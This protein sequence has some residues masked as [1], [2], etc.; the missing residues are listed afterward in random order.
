MMLNN[1]LLK[2]KLSWFKPRVIVLIESNQKQA[3]KFIFQIMP[4]SFLF[5]KEIL[6]IKNLKN[7]D[8]LQRGEY[9]ILNND[10]I[11]KPVLKKIK[12]LTFGFNQGAD[13]QISDLNQSKKTSFSFQR[14]ASLRS[15][16][17][18]RY[19]NFKINHQGNVVPI[20]LPGAFTQKEIYSVMP[21]IIIGIIFDL[22]LVEISQKLKGPIVRKDET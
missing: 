11:K 8:L 12:I 10:N 15:A 17:V 4:K 16:R 18:N 6:F 5:N 13:F 1:F 7:I 20:W 2:F 19:T 22:N 9:L 14:F 21:A 3:K